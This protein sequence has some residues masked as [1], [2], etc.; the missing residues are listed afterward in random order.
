MLVCWSLGMMYGAF[1][2]KSHASMAP[3]VWDSHGF[4]QVRKV[5]IWCD[6]LIY[7]GVDHVTCGCSLIGGCPAWRTRRFVG[8]VAS[9]QLKKKQPG[10]CRHLVSEVFFF[11]RVFCSIDLL[12]PLVCWLTEGFVSPFNNRYMSYLPCQHLAFCHLATA[13]KNAVRRTKRS[14]RH[15]PAWPGGLGWTRA[16]IPMEES[17][18]LAG[19]FLLGKIPWEFRWWRYSYMYTSFM[20]TPH[21]PCW[22]KV[23]T[24]DQALIKLWSPCLVVQ[25]LKFVVFSVSTPHFHWGHSEKVPLA[26]HGA[27]SHSA[28]AEAMGIFSQISCWI[29]YGLTNLSG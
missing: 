19:W 1:T 22:I 12:F 21:H 17:P 3:E 18:K 28:V 7:F 16:A 20:E 29:H 15:K 26:E 14:V 2:A 4:T 5:V 6:I 13:A 25:L 9:S 10:S 8:T 27:P 23:P 11:Y 24:F